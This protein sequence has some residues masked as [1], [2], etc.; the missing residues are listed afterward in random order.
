MNRSVRALKT[1]P[2]QAHVDTP[3][4]FN[5]RSGKS[6]RTAQK[7]DVYLILHD[8]SWHYFKAT[9]IAKQSNWAAPKLVFKSRKIVD[10][11]DKHQQVYLAGFKWQ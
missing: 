6:F 5:S 1:G 2:F 11:T 4:H 8:K 3:L 7:T 9:K 10:T